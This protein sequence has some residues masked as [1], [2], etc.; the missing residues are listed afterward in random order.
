MAFKYDGKGI[1]IITG[2]DVTA[3]APLDS[4]S[5]VKTLAELNSLPEN[6]LYEGLK[7][8]VEENQVE[9]TYVKSGVAD[10]GTDTFK[11]RKGISEADT[12]DV[13]DSLESDSATDALSA[14]RGKEL[15]SE[16]DS[17]NQAVEEV[18][19]RV[20]TAEGDIDALE[21]SVSG[22]DT[23]LTTAEATLAT[24]NGD[25][26]VDGSF[27]KLVKEVTEAHNQD[28]N[29]LDGRIDTLE[30]ASENYNSRLNTL[31]GDTSTEGSVAKQVYDA[32]T[33]LTNEF[34]TA[35][36]AL[37]KKIDDNKTAIETALATETK[38]REDGDSALDTKITEFDTNVR[39]DFASA[40]EELSKRI[41][42]NA[43]DIATNAGDI[44]EL[45][46]TL[47]STITTVNDHT[48]AINTLNG[49]SNT[50]GSVDYKLKEAVTDIN[51]NIDILG[52]HRTI[53]ESVNITTDGQTDIVFGSAIP[54]GY[55]VAQDS[56]KVH[57]N[58]LTYAEN[59][60]FV[61]NRSGAV[62][63]WTLNASNGGFNLETDDNVEIDYA[64]RKAVDVVY[65]RVQVDL[66]NVTITPEGD[67]E[68]DPT[69]YVEDIDLSGYTISNYYATII[70]GVTYSGTQA[71]YDEATSVLSI[72]GV[73]TEVT[74]T[75]YVV[76]AIPVE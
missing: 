30:S 75:V 33:N 55:N 68:A 18:T 60:A 73:N 26:T 52:S 37:D 64:V 50:A 45:T 71:Q 47:N 1:N 74:D 3:K 65:E 63:R 67:F 15:K 70:N 48:N 2:F 43:T 32:V 66:S 16:I 42:Q 24:V 11:W 59:T 12:F 56:I 51:K 53:V 54:D 72:A 57:V 10:D 46:N 8:Y 9:Y 76:M 19:K 31:E 29:T 58:G 28:I 23:R 41:T 22:L 6:R 7:V 49:D 35:D 5:V 27:R 61:V 38:A 44:E 4:R 39:K 36:K 21:T 14:K 20:T 34:T 40:N 13:I 69:T 17:T 25:D 62:V